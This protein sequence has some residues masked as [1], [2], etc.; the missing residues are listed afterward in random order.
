MQAFCDW[1]CRRRFD[2]VELRACCEQRLDLHASQITTQTDHRLA[3][4]QCQAR[5]RDALQP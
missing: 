3:A 1:R 5:G 2:I 4:A